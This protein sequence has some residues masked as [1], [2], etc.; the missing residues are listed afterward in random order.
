MWGTARRN[1]KPPERE[2]WRQR[3]GHL[4]SVCVEGAPNSFMCWHLPVSSTY[5][6]RRD[7][8]KPGSR[9]R[10]WGISEPTVEEEDEVE[11]CF[12]DYILLSERHAGVLPYMPTYDYREADW[13]HMM[14]LR[15]GLWTRSHVGLHCHSFDPAVVG[16][17]TGDG[18]GGGWLTPN[19][20]DVDVVQKPTLATADPLIL[21]FTRAF[22]YK[23]AQLLNDG[24]SAAIIA[25]L[26]RRNPSVN[27]Y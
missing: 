21:V 17:H 11:P 1:K 26:L 6:G 8:I 19:F 12:T 15:S 4:R 24:L 14:S 22:Y 25:T 5:R 2:K 18:A 16:K 3:Q 13:N 9:S 20:S 10:L 27:G 23:E 7:P